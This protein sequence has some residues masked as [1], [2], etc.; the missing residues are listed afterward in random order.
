MTII[1]YLLALNTEINPSLAYKSNQLRTLTYFSEFCKQKPFIKM[2]RDD[3]LAYFDSIKRPEESDPLH[4]W[5]GTYN[6]RRV[7]FLGT[8]TLNSEIRY[9]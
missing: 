7:Y 2:T 3:I 4:K 9:D 6:L 1:D 8:Y 5:I